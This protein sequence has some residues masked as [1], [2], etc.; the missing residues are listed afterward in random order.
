MSKDN[1]QCVGKSIVLSR[2]YTVDLVDWGERHDL[3]AK[4][5][6]I[7]DWFEAQLSQD[8]GSASS[9]PRDGVRR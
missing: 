1:H 5:P 7:F 4:L 2:D 6:E 8:R 3:L 9:V